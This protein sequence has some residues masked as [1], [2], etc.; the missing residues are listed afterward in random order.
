[1]IRPLLNQRH[2]HRNLELRGQ[3]GQRALNK[4]ALFAPQRWIG[5][6]LPALRQVIRQWLLP[7]LAPQVS[8]GQIGGNPV[9]PSAKITARVKTPPR[10]MDSPERLHGQIL[11]DPRVADDAHDPGVDAPLKLPKQRLEGI[12]ITFPESCQQVHG[13]SI[14]FYSLSLR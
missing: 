3:S 9:G 13:V 1:P 2:G 6:R 12:Q 4:F 8:Q 10:A 7:R 14:L 11:S 5:A